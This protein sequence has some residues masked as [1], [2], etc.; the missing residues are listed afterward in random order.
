MESFAQGLIV[1]HA[2][3]GGIALCAGLISIA[4][5][6]G[7][8]WHRVSGKIFVPS[9]TLSALSAL[10]IALMPDHFSPFLFSVG[11][12]SLYFTI[13]GYRALRFT[14]LNGPVPLGDQ[15][16]SWLMLLT[17]ID[18]VAHPLFLGYLNRWLHWELLV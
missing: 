14:K 15:L 11:I 6:K 8:K 4:S 10:V 17:G 7:L 2:A 3:T 16:L 9:M 1:F 5:K 13:S 12:L 18:M